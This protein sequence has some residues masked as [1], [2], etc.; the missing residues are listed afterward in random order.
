MTL[1]IRSRSALLQKLLVIKFRVNPLRT[2]IANCASRF[3]ALKPN[4]QRISAKVS[5]NATALRLP[6]TRARIINRSM[7]AVSGRK[8]KPPLIDQQDRSK[9][10]P[11]SF[12]ESTFSYK[13]ESA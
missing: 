2:L 9:P 6:A 12:V 10:V 13:A 3:A 7:S 5:G 1:I 8:K 11:R 4:V